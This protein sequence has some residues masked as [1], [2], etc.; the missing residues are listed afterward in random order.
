[1]RSIYTLIFFIITFAPLSAQQII[2]LTENPILKNTYA[3]QIEKGQEAIIPVPQKDGGCIADLAQAGVIYVVSGKTAIIQIDTIGLDTTFKEASC[4]NCDDLNFGTAS[5][6]LLE[7]TYI[8]TPGILLNFDNIQLEL[9]SVNNDCI[10]KEIPIVIKRENKTHFPEAIILSPEEHIQICA[11]ELELPTPLACNHF[12]DC[13][14]EYQGSEQ[15]T[16]FSTYSRPDSCFYYKS[17]RYAGVD[18]VCVVLCDKFIVCDTFHY[19]F[20]VENDG[21]ELPFLDDFSY[22]G[23]YPAI[24]HWL[25]RDPFINSSMAIEPPSLG[26]ATFDGLNRKGRPYGGG[27]G[28]SDQLTSTYINLNPAQVQSGIHLSF[29]LQ[30]Q[31]YGD[32]PEQ[33]DFVLIEFKNSTGEWVPQDTILGI[34]SGTPTDTIYPFSFYRYPVTDDFLHDDFQFRFSNFSDRKGMFDPWHL[35]YVRL[36]DESAPNGTFADIAFTQSPKPI[37]K[38]YTSMP[39]SHFEVNVAEEL[40]TNLNIHLYNHFPEQQ[41]ADPSTVSLGEITTNTAIFQEPYTLLELPP[42]APENQRDLQPGIH[43]KFD[44]P[45][46][47]SGFQSVMENAFSGQDSLE[48]LMEYTIAVSEQPVSEGLE[49]ITRNDKVQHQT[50]FYNYFAHD[51]GT[52]ES[53]IVA[54]SF[55][56][57]AV[58]FTANVDDSLRAIQMHIPHTSIDISNQLLNLKVWIGELDEEPEYKEVF[59]RPY[60]ADSFLDTLQGF[61]TYVLVNELIPDELAP[62]YLPAGDFYIGWQQAIDCQETQCIPVGYDRNTPD[63]FQFIYRNKGAGWEQLP[64]VFPAGAVMIR[65]VVGST[66]PIPTSTEEIAPAEEIALHIFPNPASDLLNIDLAEGN[67][68]DYQLEIFNEVGQ[69]LKSGALKRTFNVKSLHSGFYLLRVTNLQTRE[70]RNERVV[71]VKDR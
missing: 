5:L 16:Y 38:N 50:N 61:T 20:H 52:A 18:S 55:V 7:I 67:Y 34:K 63:A 28:R 13:E 71:I 1:M 59:Q 32:R 2:P 3:E 12:F 68:Q 53:N 30:P 43:K 46:P 47:E 22:D 21:L 58:K 60:Y 54:Q 4:L 66:T 56:E 19:A 70:T 35:D 14:D 17:S 8:S 15:L 23:P 24:S 36:A 45:S 26:V 31:G 29:W 40:S 48:F 25:D 37:L 6:D 65:P 42:L 69:L 27:Y 44:N 49:A 33:A 39:W 62:L 9:C 57:V 51:D 41:T 10:T 11:D 64:E